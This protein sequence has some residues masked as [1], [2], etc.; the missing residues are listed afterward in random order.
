MAKINHEFDLYE[1]VFI[2]PSGYTTEY[3]EFATYSLSMGFLMS[4]PALIY[5]GET[6]GMEVENKV[7]QMI[8]DEEFA[9]GAYYNKF[10]IFYDKNAKPISWQG[11]E[12]DF[13]S[14]RYL[15]FA[16]YLLSQRCTPCS[17]LTKKEGLFHP[18]F[19]LVQFANSQDKSEK[20]YRLIILSRNLT[21]AHYYETGIV[22]ESTDECVGDNGVGDKIRKF[23]ESYW[24]ATHDKGNSY[25][26][27][28][29]YRLSETK[30][31]LKTKI[32]TEKPVEIDLLFASQLQENFKAEINE[33]IK[34]YDSCNVI[35]MKP[36]EGIIETEKMEMS[37]ICNFFDM[38]EDGA[39]TNYK[40][41]KDA[42]TYWY[43]KKSEKNYSCVIEN[44]EHKKIPILLHSKMYIFWNSKE[45][46]KWKGLVY[47]G[48]ANCSENALEG[49]NEELLLKMEFNGIQEDFS[50]PTKSTNSPANF[51]KRY[52][53]C[54][55]EKVKKDEIEVDEICEE[56]FPILSYEI[57]D[58]DV[59]VDNSN[60]NRIQ[61]TFK[62]K[63][64]EAVPINVGLAKRNRIKDVIVD[65]G[66]EK[67]ITIKVTQ[68]SF[69]DLIVLR[70]QN[71]N[72]L[73]LDSLKLD[74]K[75]EK[76][77]MILDDLPIFIPNDL[78]RLI[79]SVH[80][81]TNVQDNVYEKLAKH[82]LYCNDFDKVLK[83]SLKAIEKIIARDEKLA[84]K[85]NEL[86]KLGEKIF[87]EEELYEDYKDMRQEKN[88]ID[89][90]RA[91]GLDELKKVITVLKN[92]G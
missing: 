15:I 27:I 81:M 84:G 71:E 29:L 52:T 31:A 48:S 19:I 74:W 21:F 14:S 16:N 69:S 68:K 38:Y 56:E 10:H 30:F 76:I 5:A 50:L 44:K 61:I 3:V 22:L 77:S 67:E 17:P 12:F 60:S 58:A 37:Y 40:R 7:F 49:S 32:E 55:A 80:G 11:Q 92:G 23:I 45:K 91:K 26:G 13:L 54:S 70:K 20:R 41:K 33:S 85:L 63:N 1:D 59:L 62:V 25:E 73:Y 9:K 4:I 86:E 36:T 6:Y 75:G 42:S 46:Y 43:K 39:N 35:S 72:R 65:S 53:Y 66:E 18:K 82:R 57:K 78:S 90:L 34:G 2:P 83:K 47:A 8:R 51:D 89:E 88:S 87:S 64:K 28:D 24:G 79:P